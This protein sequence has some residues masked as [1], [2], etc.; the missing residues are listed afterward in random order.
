MPVLGFLAPGSPETLGLSVV[1]LRK[2]LSEAGLVE[3]RDLI[4]EF[5]WARD[6]VDQLPK[7]AAELVQRQVTVIYALASVSARAAKDG[8]RKHSDRL[9]KRRRSSRSR[10]CRKPWTTRRQHDGDKPARWRTRH[11]AIG[12]AA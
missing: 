3:G 4:I 7:L 9:P 2:G 6:Q 1:A 12:A 11:E 10:A 8:N 5:R